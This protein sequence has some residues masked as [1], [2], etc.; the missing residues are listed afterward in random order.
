V[1][2]VLLITT[3]PQLATWVGEVLLDRGFV[4]DELRGGTPFVY[5]YD[6]QG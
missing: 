5:G 6:R 4:Q 2:R 3:S 1:D